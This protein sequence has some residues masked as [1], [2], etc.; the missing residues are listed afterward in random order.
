MNT[1]KV[2]LLL[3][4]LASQYR[5]NQC[6]KNDRFR[7]SGYP[8]ASPAARKEYKKTREFKA[9]PSNQS[10][11]NRVFKAHEYWQTKM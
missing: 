4:H 2:M 10:H 5:N 7:S 3:S 9:P 8:I 6:F 1:F 11:S